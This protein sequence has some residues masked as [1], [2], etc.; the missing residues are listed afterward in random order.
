MLQKL[1][2]RVSRPQVFLELFN[3]GLEVR[4]GTDSWQRRTSVGRTVRRR[5]ANTRAVSTNS[6]DA[7][8][9]AST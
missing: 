9:D 4:Q 1:G 8:Q 2:E 7:T 5:Q 3:D 6:R